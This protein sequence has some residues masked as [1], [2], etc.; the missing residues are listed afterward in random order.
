MSIL[1]SRSDHDLDKLISEIKKLSPDAKL[2]LSEDI[3]SEEIEISQSHQEIVAERLE[4]AKL[5]PVRM[6]EWVLV[7]DF[8]EI[9]A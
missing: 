9:K 3:W 6:K 4:Q 7:K 5:N 2:R 8:L 1:P